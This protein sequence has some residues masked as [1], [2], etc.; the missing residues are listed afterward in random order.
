MISNRRAGHGARAIHLATLVAAG[1]VVLPAGL[2]GASA[3]HVSND[4]SSTTVRCNGGPIQTYTCD[5]RSGAACAKEAIAVLC[6]NVELSNVTSDIGG[7]ARTVS[8][9]GTV[10]VGDSFDVNLQLTANEAVGGFD[11]QLDYDEGEVSLLSVQLDTLNWSFLG[12]VTTA[13]GSVSLSAQAMGGSVSGSDIPIATFSLNG[14]AAGEE[15]LTLDL[16][17]SEL[18]FAGT[19]TEDSVVFQSEPFTIPEPAS[20]ILLGLGVSACAHR[21]SR[22]RSAGTSTVES[23][24]SPHSP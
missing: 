19:P 18:V 3:A 16:S 6:D 22:T 7:L 23:E 13:P 12:P 17:A 5:S 24:D 4:S 10:L 15:A 1:A 8:E 20:A 21:R 11:L 9:S 2:A 14:M